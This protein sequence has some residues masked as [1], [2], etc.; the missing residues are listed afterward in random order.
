MPESCETTCHSRSMGVGDARASEAVVAVEVA[1]CRIQS[2]Y[3]LTYT[4][5]RFANVS[6]AGIIS[7]AMCAS[8]LTFELLG[9]V[10]TC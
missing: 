5:T 10:F 1:I 3:F 9:E 8:A 2:N 7:V 4:S 6:A